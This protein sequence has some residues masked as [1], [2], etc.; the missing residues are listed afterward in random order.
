MTGD[1]VYTVAR[2]FDG[3]ERDF[4]LENLINIGPG[5]IAGERGQP[6][7]FLMLDEAACMRMRLKIDE[8]CDE[9]E[10]VNADFADLQEAFAGNEEYELVRQLVRQLHRQLH[11]QPALLPYAP[12]LALQWTWCF[13]HFRCGTAGRRP[14]CDAA[15]LAHL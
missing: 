2:R 7:R 4:H 6:L 8:A 10:D 1:R 13:P 12:P 3:E 11:R 14:R 9:L 5:A 15:P